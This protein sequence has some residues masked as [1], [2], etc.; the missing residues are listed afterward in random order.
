MIKDYHFCASVSVGP[1]PVG[2]KF[3]FRRL[4]VFHLEQ[5]ISSFSLGLILEL[6][7][8][9][10]LVFCGIGFWGFLKAYA[11]RFS[12]DFV[13]AYCDISVQHVPSSLVSI[14]PVN[15]F[16]SSLGFSVCLFHGAVSLSVFTYISSVCLALHFASVWFWLCFFLSLFLHHF[17]NAFSMN[18][19][20]F[21]VW[22]SWLWGGPKL[23]WSLI[24][25]LV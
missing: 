4:Y 11:T 1:W 25:K 13:T 20:F 5:S 24:L 6:L 2:N 17:L 7:D 3:Y 10:F 14:Y 18:S 9:Y 23:L 19:T 22:V 8:E 15:Y 16:G 21:E 12:K